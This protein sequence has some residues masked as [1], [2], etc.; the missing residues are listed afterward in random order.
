LE[1][2]GLDVERESDPLNDITLTPTEYWQ[3]ISRFYDGTLSPQ[4][5]SWYRLA[6]VVA[7]TQAREQGQ[8]LL[9]LPW[10][11]DQIA[12]GQLNQDLLII[13]GLAALVMQIDGEPRSTQNESV[14]PDS[15]G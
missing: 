13:L 9:P 7:E 10:Q 4:E 5:I 15:S 8:S 2:V 11:D 3:A 14:E 12:P 1:W 6:S